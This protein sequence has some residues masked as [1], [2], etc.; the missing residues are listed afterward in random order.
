MYGFR[1][2]AA[3]PGMTWTS[4]SDVVIFYLG[5]GGGGGKV[6]VAREWDERWKTLLLVDLRE[7]SFCVCVQ[8][9]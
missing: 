9:L 3:F 1:F 6:S 4:V 8:T 5:G 7:F 2:D